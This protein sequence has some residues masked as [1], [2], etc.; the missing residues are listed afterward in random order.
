MVLFWIS[1]VLGIAAVIALLFGAV[2]P[3]LGLLV[4]AVVLGFLVEVPA[5]RFRRS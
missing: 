2:G 1:I 3:G 4:V 5:T